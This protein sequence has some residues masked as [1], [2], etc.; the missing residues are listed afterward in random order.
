MTVCGLQEKTRVQGRYTPKIQVEKPVKLEVMPT[1]LV[2]RFPNG[3]SESLAK[4]HC[5]EGG[6]GKMVLEG[7]SSM[8]MGGLALLFPG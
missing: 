6:P 8:L 3:L 1:V 5:T 2:L 7:P 4:P